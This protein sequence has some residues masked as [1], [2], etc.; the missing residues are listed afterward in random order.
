MQ[1]QV[2]ID[3]AALLFAVAGGVTLLLRR[4]GAVRR[5]LLALEELALS[6]TPPEPPASAPADPARESNTPTGVVS[7]G[8]TNPPLPI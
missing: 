3:A 8:L 7:P 2:L 6:S 1:D 5:S 4:L